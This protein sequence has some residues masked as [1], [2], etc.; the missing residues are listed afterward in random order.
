MPHQNFHG[1]RG[2]NH[3][4]WQ[5]KQDHGRQRHNKP[6]RETQPQ[7]NVSSTS[8]QQS[9]VNESGGEQS[10]VKQS[11]QSN[12]FIPLQVSLWV[13]YWGTALWS[14]FLYSYYKIVQSICYI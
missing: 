1:G 7:D 11:S 2:S 10:P 12:P 6:Y 4:N 9:T 13:K 8:F 3:G 5:Q 14:S